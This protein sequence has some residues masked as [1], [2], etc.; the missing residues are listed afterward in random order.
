MNSHG[1]SA[2]RWVALLCLLIG[3]SAA[4]GLH[5]ALQPRIDWQRLLKLPAV[6]PVTV[7]TSRNTQATQEAPAPLAPA[8]KATPEQE[9]PLA[10]AAA[11]EAPAPRQVRSRYEL[12]AE[13]SA[14]PEQPEGASSQETLGPA[15][16]TGWQELPTLLQPDIFAAPPTALPESLP[17]L[18]APPLEEPA[19]ETTASALLPILEGAEAPAVPP[20][21]PLHA[22]QPGGPV[23]VMEVFV[24]D[25]GTVVDA[26]IAVPSA[27]PL[28]DFGHLL[29]ERRAR[30]SNL[31]PPLLPGEIR[32]LER[33]IDYRLHNNLRPSSNLP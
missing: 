12:Q 8:V 3:A 33:R 30:W 15:E 28:D 18:A 17:R 14:P 11:T 27:Y 22:E 23:L 4:W 1:Q 9:T 29:I 2:R 31:V 32:K 10:Q 13:V 19:P 16:A 5:A 6:V 24:N 20:E 25:Q 21:A 7:G 26:R